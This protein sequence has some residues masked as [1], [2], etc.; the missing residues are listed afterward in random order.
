MREID[1]FSYIENK[2]FQSHPMS[3]KHY[4]TFEAMR[5]IIIDKR[6]LA[7]ALRNVGVIGKVLL[8][9]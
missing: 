2:K 8:G 9:D 7:S 1:L 5:L 4:C 6:I 3:I